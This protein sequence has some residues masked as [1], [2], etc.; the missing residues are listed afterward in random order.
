MQCIA[1][2]KNYGMNKISVYRQQHI[3]LHMAM[4]VTK[5]KTLLPLSIILH[6]KE[7]ITETD[8]QHISQTYGLISPDPRI[9]IQYTQFW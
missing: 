2:Q 7:I 9:L 8:I 1:G 3:G 5:L 4:R 6:T